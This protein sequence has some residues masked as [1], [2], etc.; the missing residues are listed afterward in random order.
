MNLAQRKAKL[1]RTRLPALPDPV[2]EAATLARLM[3]DLD[4]TAAKLGDV[5]PPTAAQLEQ[6]QRDFEAMFPSV[7]GA[8]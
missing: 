4:R 3:A 2:D 5:K 7:A 1:L 8:W 6:F